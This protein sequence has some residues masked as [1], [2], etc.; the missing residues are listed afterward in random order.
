MKSLYT[1][2]RQPTPETVNSSPLVLGLFHS[3][4]DAQAQIT[5][6]CPADAQWRP[7]TPGHRRWEL[8]TGRYLYVVEEISVHEHQ[9]LAANMPAGEPSPNDASAN[10]MESLRE[11]TSHISECLEESAAAARES[12][13]NW[14]LQSL[15]QDDENLRRLQGNERFYLGQ[16]AAF[17]WIAGCLDRLVGQS[18]DESVDDRDKES[19][20]TTPERDGW[21]PH[22]YRL[23]SS[24]G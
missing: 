23:S 11:L 7:P 13:E 20:A 3:V 17:A 16:A 24:A 8:H 19:T 4:S 6:S 22:D 1:L 15:N 21:A 2:F 14:M 5:K 9:S 12:H 18:P 10:L